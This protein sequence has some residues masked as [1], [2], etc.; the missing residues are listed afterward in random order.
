LSR[1][2]RVFS[3]QAGKVLSARFL[4]PSQAIWNQKDEATRVSIHFFCERRGILSPTSI[5]APFFPQAIQHV[6]I[7]LSLTKKF[8]TN[9]KNNFR[10]GVG[11]HGITGA[12]GENNRNTKTALYFLL[13]IDKR[14]FCRNM[15]EKISGPPPS[16]REEHDDAYDVHV[17]ERS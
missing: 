12:S 16:R 13:H 11:A 2:C 4:V 6:L 14:H 17:Y 1:I 15:R 10:I 3:Q 7:R 5:C 9:E 8:S